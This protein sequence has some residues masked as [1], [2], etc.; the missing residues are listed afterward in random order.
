MIDSLD[1][2]G[3]WQLTFTDHQRF[4]KPEL[5]TGEEI[6]ESRFI[7]AQVPGEVHLDAQRAGLISDVYGGLGSL[8]ARWIEECEWTYR[9]WIEVPAAALTGRAWLSFECLDLVARVVLNGQEVG[10]H[11]NSFLP[12][13]IEVTGKLKPGRNLLC[14]QLESGL[15]S[16]AEKPSHPYNESLETAL[17]KRHW[18]RKPQCQAGWDWSPRLLNVG[19]QGPCRLEWTAAAARVDRL[20][21]LATLSEDHARGEVRA[22]LFVEGLVTEETPA[23]LCVELPDAGIRA[24]AEVRLKPGLHAYEVVARVEK[25]RLWWPVGHG[26]QP[27]YRVRATL[28][29]AAGEI[30]AR[31]ARVGFRRV[32]LDETPHP[33]GGRWCALEVNGRRIFCK[34]GN[35]VP[36]DIIRA[37]IDRERYVALVEHSLAANFNLLRVWGGGLYEADEFYDLCDERGI[38]VWQ[39]FIFACSKYPGTDQA[40]YESIKA[41][42]THQLRRLAAHPSLFLWCGNNEIEWGYWGWGYDRGAV[43]PDHNLYHHLLPRLAAV[44]DPTRLYRPS[45]PFSPDHLEP[46][47]DDVGDQHPWSLGFADTDFR[48]YRAMACRFPNEGGFLGPNALPTLMEAL[49]NQPRIGSATWHAHDNSIAAWP[50][51]K[52][53]VDK[54]TDQWVG[55]PI[56]TLSPEEWVYWAGLL[57][58]EALRE[59]CD[60]FHRRMFDSAAAVFWMYND[61][62]PCSRSWTIVDYRLRRTPA[63]HPVRRA[64]SPVNVVVVEEGASVAVYGINEGREPVAAEL[65]Y[66]LFAIAGGWPLDRRARVTLAPNASTRIAEFA[67][68]EWHDERATLAAAVLERDGRLIARNRLVLPLFK[69]LAWA[70]ARP[71][72]E[73]RDG[74]ATFTS[75]T[76]AWGVCLDLDGEAALADNFFDL[77]PGVPYSIPWSGREAPRVLRVGNLAVDRAASASR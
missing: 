44:E 17:H 1:L 72:V 74:V 66:G 8:Q 30:G 25:P 33:Q 55:K 69:E 23:R 18:L 49:G 27:L 61:T 54:M 14:V 16:V 32:R 46:N 28:T 57:Q 22:R 39:E 68:A 20:V 34:G 53:A 63:F 31:E 47:R 13:R 36:A 43:L 5:A 15:F 41:E 70:P 48:K 35:F 67:R 40:F 71:R 45:S 51:T 75:D 37:S 64:L 3:T 50:W 11:A 12:C 59:Y 77:Y 6:D 21:P 4:T 7:T 10:R 58:G 62:W 76:F 52:G 65:R 29:T 19:I 73:L 26:E 38:L 2:G 24:E 42:A 60:N 56:A 9:R